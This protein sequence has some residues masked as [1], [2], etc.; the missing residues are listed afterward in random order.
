LRLT[1][2]TIPKEYFYFALALGAGYMW[3]IISEIFKKAYPVGVCLFKY[4]TGIPCP[5]CGATRSVN[6]LTH[7]DFVTAFK[8]NPLGIIIFIILVVA[9]FWIM[10][11]LIRRKYT[12]R[13][14]YYKTELLFKNK[15]VYIPFIIL[16]A[17]N[18]FWNINKNL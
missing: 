1:N 4:T 9:P 17:L 18:W 6:F 13:S 2:K 7:G 3:L 11:D 10:V 16:I 8:I 14:F 15:L 12:L 5:S